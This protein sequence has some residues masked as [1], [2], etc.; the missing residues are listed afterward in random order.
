MGQSKVA[1]TRQDNALGLAS[2]NVGAAQV[3]VGVCTGGTPGTR[4][5]FTSKTALVAAL[6]GGPAV[7][8]AAL[9][10]DEQ[11]GQVDVIPVTAS[12]SGTAGTIASVSGT[13]TPLPTIAGTPNDFYEGLLKIIVGGAVATATFQYSL[14]GGNNWSGTI[15]TASTYVIPGTG[16]TITWTAGTYIAADVFGWTS[17]PSMFS[18]G[19]LTTALNALNA[20]VGD[21]SI[22]HIVGQP[23][24]INDAAKATAAAAIAA[25]CETAAA[26]GAVLYHYARFVTEMPDVS[27]AS[28]ITA[29]AATSAPDVACVAGFVQQVSA[30]TGRINKRSAAWSICSRLQ[31]KPLGQDPARVDV[32]PLPASVVS[33]WRNEAATPGLDDARFTTLCTYPGGS[34]ASG[35]AVTGFYITNMPL[36]SPAGSDFKYFQHGQVMDEACRIVVSVLRMSISQDIAIND[37]ATIDEGEARAIERKFTTRLSDG[38]VSKRAVSAAAGVVNRTD[39]IGQ[40]G[41]L[42]A[43]V[44]VRPRGYVK[45]LAATVGFSFKLASAPPQQ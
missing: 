2:S 21:Y 26:A 41:L 31:N 29:F 10:L 44:R 9:V 18:T 13:G 42:R 23:G 35:T 45:Q 19:D 8:A 40:T 17:T 3:K 5:K 22:C 15:T 34:V 20:D 4:Y 28:L 38:L 24:G 27:D 43:D 36:M 33:I 12:V 14:D 37:D 11:G 16:L 39:L 6:T 7:E 32:G 30:V 1:I 25:V